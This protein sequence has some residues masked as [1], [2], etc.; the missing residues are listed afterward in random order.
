MRDT[1]GEES[2]LRSGVSDDDDDDDVASSSGETAL[3]DLMFERT[4][5]LTGEGET[6]SLGEGVGTLD[7]VK[8]EAKSRREA[9]RRIWE[10]ERVWEKGKIRE[11]VLGLYAA[12][13]IGG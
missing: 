3:T 13:V 6:A 9:K 10:E 1:D 2:N 5:P 7:K 11:V 12:H 4:P 8:E